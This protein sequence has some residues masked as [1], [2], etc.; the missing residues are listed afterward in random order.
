MKIL[1]RSDRWQNI[2]G[3]WCCYKE[4]SIID[5]NEEVLWYGE[6]SDVGAFEAEQYEIGTAFGYA[7]YYPDF[8]SGEALAKKFGI[9][10][11][12]LIYGTGQDE[13]VKK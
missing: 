5:D 1:K 11:D 12:E 3:N 2:E 13:K 8:S 6:I 4:R 10:I 9:E 7:D